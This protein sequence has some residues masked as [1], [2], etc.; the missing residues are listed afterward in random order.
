MD[1]RTFIGAVVAGTITAPLA[2]Y[3]QTATSVRRIGVL[4]PDARP[5]P[6]LLQQIYAPLSERGW[7]EGK[8]LLIERRDANGSAELLRTSAEELVR[9]EVEIIVTNGTSAALAAK[10]A[11]TTIPIVMST[12]SAPSAPVSSRAWLG[13]AAISPAFPLL[14]QRLTQSASPCCASCCR[15]CN[16]SASWRIQPIH[17]GAPRTKSLSRRADHL[18]CN[19]SL[20]K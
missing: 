20:S 16:A 7:T 2:A 13:L 19:R 12:V 8:N 14:A 1:R 11:T 4:S 18:A 3:A 5:T 15:A 10:N 17:I 6:A 9:L